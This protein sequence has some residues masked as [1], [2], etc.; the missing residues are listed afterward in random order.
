MSPSGRRSTPRSRSRERAGLDPRRSRIR[1]AQVY[2]GGGEV[3]VIDIDRT[4]VG[5]L[6]ALEGASVTCH[7]AAFEMSFFEHAD[8]ALGEVHCTLQAVS[9]D[10]RREVDVSR[11]RR[12]GL[13]RRDPGQDGAD[14][15]LGRCTS[16][17]KNSST[18][19]ALDAVVEWQVAEHVF[20]ALRDQTPA[21]EIQIRRRRR[22]DAHAGPWIQ[23]RSRRRMRRLIAELK[24]ERLVAEREYREAC[25]KC[26]QRHAR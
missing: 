3:L 10:V 5:V 17:R 23:V 4:G 24:L 14:R 21:Y 13:S 6:T 22:G 11:R 20:P 15:Q 9:F 25:L 7:N 19:A 12:R 2:D 1:L 18:Y 26:G 8:I 16:C